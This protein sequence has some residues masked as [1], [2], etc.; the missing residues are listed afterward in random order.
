MDGIINVRING[1][2]LTKDS[3]RAGVQH[4]GNAVSLIIEFDEG[5]DKY[6]KTITFW[7]AIGENPVKIALD[8]VHLEDILSS[9]R[10]YW[11]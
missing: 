3:R 8:T 6:A 11:C 5:W 10:I 7:N 1:N 9:T 4:E 2:H